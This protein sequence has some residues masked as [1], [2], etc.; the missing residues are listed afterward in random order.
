AATII[1]YLLGDMFI[2]QKFGNVAASI[3]DFGLA[4]VT[5]WILG[6]LFIEGSGAI[7]ITS[8]AAAFLTACIEPF[9]HGYILD[10]FSDFRQKGD[11]RSMNQQL[12]TEFAEEMDIKGHRVK[13]DHDS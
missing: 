8:L 9:I 12:Q 4:F 13:Q 1:S 5:Y 6:S 7:L 2:L 3:A 11:H 10:Q